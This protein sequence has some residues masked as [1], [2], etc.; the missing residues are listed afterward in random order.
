MGS[1]YAILELDKSSSQDDIR[2]SYKRLAL[3]YHPDKN[4]AAYDDRFPQIKAAYDILSDPIKRDVYDAQYSSRDK[5]NYSS[6]D[7]RDFINKMVKSMYTIMRKNAFPDDII[8][9][10]KVD[11]HEIYHKKI[12]KLNIK[13]KR[14]N[15]DEFMS[16]HSVIYIDLMNYQS[17]YRCAG[18]GDA[19]MFRK[20][21]N[22]DI[23][24]KL[25]INDE[26]DVSVPN[27]FSLYDISVQIPVT[28]HSF[29]TDT[30]FKVSSLLNIEIPNERKTNYVLK[31]M[32]LPF[33]SEDAEEMR[34][35]IYVCLKIEM[36]TDPPCEFVDMLKTI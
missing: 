19:S 36:P 29:Y 28:L 31:G 26:A 20:L 10:L 13:V 16:D 18:K 34:G 5:I 2:K 27:I 17:E 35:D 6:V 8:I 9:T 32:G 23:I 21:S 12:K 25:R 30:S 11:I 22:S 15:E 4:H 7:W 33:F 14:W 1:L 24:V 3:K